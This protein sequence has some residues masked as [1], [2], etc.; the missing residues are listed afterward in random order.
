MQSFCQ[1]DKRWATAK[2]GQSQLNLGRF[3]CTS[4]CIADISTYFGD[5]L[6][7]LQISQK[8]QYING[9]VVWKSCMFPHFKFEWREYGRNDKNISKALADKKRAVIIQVASGS[10][11]VVVIGNVKGPYRIA[12]PWFGDFADM[13][14]YDNDITGAAYFKANFI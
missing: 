12:D 6:N 3:G 11:W 1:R 4:V 7:P 9:L 10:H 14:R 2:L 13:N 8:I 5:N